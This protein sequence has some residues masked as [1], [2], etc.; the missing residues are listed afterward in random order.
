MVSLNGGPILLKTGNIKPH[1][2][3]LNCLGTKSKKRVL[4]MDQNYNFPI[5][6]RTH[7]DGEIVINKS[8]LLILCTIRVRY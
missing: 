5:I 2:V 1:F 7:E 4:F 3:D 8:Y 6:I